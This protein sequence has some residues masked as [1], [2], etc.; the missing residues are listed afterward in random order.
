VRYRRC[1][2]KPD[3]RP[4]AAAG[5]AAAPDGLSPEARRAEIEA[6]KR[7]AMGR[8]QT[9]ARRK[10]GDRRRLNPEVGAAASS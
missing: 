4:I 6:R 5:S 2:I 10:L 8:T 1:Q 9:H 7:F 3:C